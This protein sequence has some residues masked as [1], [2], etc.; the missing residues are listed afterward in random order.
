[1]KKICLIDYDMSARGGVEQ[2]TARLANSL[3]GEYEVHVLSL[4]QKG[5]L[6]KTVALSRH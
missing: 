3:S 4:C 5:S 6:A 2:M 1:M